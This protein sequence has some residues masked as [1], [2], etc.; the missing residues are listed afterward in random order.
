MVS[1]MR[2][3]DAR[4]AAAAQ[5]ELLHLTHALGVWLIAAWRVY[6]SY[7]KANRVESGVRDYGEVVRLLA[8][9]RFDERWRPVLK[10]PR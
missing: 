6:D 2:S 1:G 5:P 7:L 3:W 4:A 9:T 10:A 8:G